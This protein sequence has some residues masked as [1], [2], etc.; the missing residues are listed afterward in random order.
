MREKVERKRD[1]LNLQVTNLM[2]VKNGYHI[3]RT[4]SKGG[5]K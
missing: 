1:R 4:L 2:T 5:M 3:H